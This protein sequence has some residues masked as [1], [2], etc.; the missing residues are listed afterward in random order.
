MV[1]V[2]CE[3]AIEYGSGYYG[4][5]RSMSCSCEYDGLTGYS[6]LF[7]KLNGVACIVMSCVWWSV[8]YGHVRCPG[9]SYGLEN[10]SL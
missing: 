5:V 8:V 10:R 9:L 4:V 2:Y 1:H 7:M 6:L 3:S